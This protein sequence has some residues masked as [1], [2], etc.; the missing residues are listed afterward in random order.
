[1]DRIF[2]DAFYVNRLGRAIKN[3]DHS[4]LFAF[5]RPGGALIVKLIPSLARFIPKYELSSTGINR[6]VKHFGRGAAFL[7]YQGRTP[8]GK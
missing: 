7:A 2:L 3:T 1:M 8:L 4:H 5:E 6:S